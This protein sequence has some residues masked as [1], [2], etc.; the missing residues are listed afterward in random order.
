MLRKDYDSKGLVAKKSLVVSFK[1]LV[2]KT[3][4]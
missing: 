1:G 3:N 2:A 4:R